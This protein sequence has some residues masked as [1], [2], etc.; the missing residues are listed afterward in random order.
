VLFDGMRA[1]TRL[2]GANVV[3]MNARLLSSLQGGPREPVEKDIE[4]PLWTAASVME[5]RCFLPQTAQ[6]KGL[7]KGV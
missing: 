5:N 7:E 1:E 4:K 2:N 6:N 3:V